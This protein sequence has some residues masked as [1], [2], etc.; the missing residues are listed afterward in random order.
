MYFAFALVNFFLDL[1]G[2]A[3][4]NWRNGIEVF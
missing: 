4:T 3:D 2:A 1:T